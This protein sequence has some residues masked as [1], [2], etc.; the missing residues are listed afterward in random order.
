MSEPEIKVSEEFIREKRANFVF[1]NHKNRT[2]ALNKNNNSLV[3]VLDLGFGKN[4]GKALIEH[5]LGSLTEEVLFEDLDFH[6]VCFGK[7]SEEEPVCQS[8]LAAYICQRAKNKDFT[9]K[10]KPTK[11]A[12]SFDL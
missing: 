6:D 1:K 7:H 2:I 12:M 4:E 11:K 10:D 3:I 5:L 8:C 9:Y